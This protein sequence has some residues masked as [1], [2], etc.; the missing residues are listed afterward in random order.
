M[1]KILTALVLLII[2][3]CAFPQSLKNSAPSE[4]PEVSPGVTVSETTAPAAMNKAVRNFKKTFKSITDQKWYEMPDG[5]RVN[6]TTNDVRYR[7]DYDKKGNWL[8]TIRYYDEKKLPVEVRR[9]VASSYLDY[10]IR[11]VEEIEAPRNTK[12]HVIH[13]EGETN[14][15]NIKV[16]DN[17]IIELEKIKKS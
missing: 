7:L 3:N 12:F 6:F 8:H 13:L 2:G 9:L 15:I 17:E 14:W 11:T 4:N 16:S 10:N 1:K 5:Y